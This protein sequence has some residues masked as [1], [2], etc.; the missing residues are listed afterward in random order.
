MNKRASYADIAIL[1]AAIIFTSLLLVNKDPNIRATATIG[2]YQHDL[3][4]SYIVAENSRSYIEHSYGYAVRSAL[5]S[6]SYCTD[7]DNNE[8]AFLDR[9]ESALKTSYTANI[10]VEAN[11]FEITKPFQTATAVSDQFY[12]IP[13]NAIELDTKARKLTITPE[14]ISVINSNPNFRVTTSVDTKQVYNL[15]LLCSEEGDVPELLDI[16]VP[17]PE[18]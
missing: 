11:G 14:P 15:K 1:V 7:P 12:N 3:M 5:Y 2:E 10:P 9:V 6:S 16:T 17:L 8:K 13:S 4:D 18:V